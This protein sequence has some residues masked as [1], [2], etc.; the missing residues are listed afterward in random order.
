MVRGEAAWQERLGGLASEALGGGLVLHRARRRRERR[1]GLAGLAALPPQR[2]LHIAPCRS[3]H[4][5]GMRFALDLVWVGADGRVVRVDRAVGPWRVRTCLSARSVVETL[6]GEGDR[7]AAT[8]S[9]RSDAT[10]S[11]A[12][13]GGY[14]GPR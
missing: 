12:A 14:T 6:A 13:E 3:I 5:V 9:R 2:G 11:A 8:L 10:P 1:R 7:F 4:T